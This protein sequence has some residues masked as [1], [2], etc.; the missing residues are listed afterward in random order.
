MSNAAPDTNAAH[1]TSAAH[2][3]TAAPA[4]Q[5]A[6]PSLFVGLTAVALG[7]SGLADRAGIVSLH[8]A[9]V[10]VAAAV[11]LSLAVSARS[12]RRLAAG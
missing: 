6:W 2:E 7:L 1:E 10:P 12:V 8:P 11:A 3:T 5:W 9:V 4:Q